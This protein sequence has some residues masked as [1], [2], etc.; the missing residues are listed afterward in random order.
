[1]TAFIKSVLLVE[2]VDNACKYGESIK[3]SRDM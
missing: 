2:I 3:M 1:M